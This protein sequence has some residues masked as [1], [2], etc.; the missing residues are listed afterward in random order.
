MGNKQLTQADVSGS[1][2]EQLASEALRVAKGY[3]EESGQDSM[4]ALERI[5]ARYD[6]KW[7]DVSQNERDVCKALQETPGLRADVTAYLGYS[8]VMRFADYLVHLFDQESISKE[9]ITNDYLR[10]ALIVG[11]AERLKIV[12]EALRVRK[13]SLLA[14]AW[15]LLTQATLEKRANSILKKLDS[16]A[17]AGTEDLSKA[18]QQ[19]VEAVAACLIAEP[20]AIAGVCEAN[21][22]P[23]PFRAVHLKEWEEIQKLRSARGAG[24]W[25]PENGTIG[26]ALSGGGIRSATFNLGVLQGLADLKLLPLFDYLSTVSGGG[27]IGSWL[28]AWLKR[29]ARQPAIEE[30]QES[31]SPARNPDPWSEQTRP[32]RWL[33]SFSNYLTPS[34]G[35]FSADVWTAAATY[36][37]NLILNLGVLVPGMAAVLLI[38]RMAGYWLVHEKELPANVNVYASVLLMALAI[39]AMSWNLRAVTTGSRQTS[40]FYSPGYIQWAIV[41]P[42]CASA[43]FISRAFWTGGEWLFS[44]GFTPDWKASFGVLFAGVAMLQIFG[45]FL[46][47]F[48]DRRGWRGRGRW[49]LPR[50]I[51]AGL[52]LIGVAACCALAGVLL[53]RC[54]GAALGF[55]ESLDLP[56]SRWHW[57]IWGPPLLVLVSSLIIILQMGLS[58]LNF[59]DA[60]REWLGRL[61]AC[62]NIW[63]VA[64]LALFSAAIYGPWLIPLAARPVGKWI[65][66]GAAASWALLTIGS[67]LGARSPATAVSKG[68]SA[69][70]SKLDLLV[71]YGPYVFMIGFVVL[72]SLGVHVVLS[73]GALAADHWSCLN[74]GWWQPANPDGWWIASV[75]RLLIVSIVLAAL[76]SWRID[77]NEF[78]MHHF[79]KNRLVRC[80]LGASNRGRNPNPF[81][82]FD[83]NDDTELANLTTGDYS[84]PFPIIN[85]TLNVT[86]GTD[87]AWQQ[88]KASSFVFTPLYSGFEMWPQTRRPNDR[89]LHDFGFRKTDQYAYGGG[90]KIGTAAAIS[91]AAANPN[92]G[93]HTSTA[94]AFL[95]TVFNVRLGWW[96]G[97]PRR[98]SKYPPGNSQYQKA[99][100]TW[101]LAYLI[102]NL[103]G[104]TDA[105]AGFVNLSDGGHFDNMGLYELIRRRC[106]YIVVCDAEEDAK[107]TFGGLAAAL[108]RCRADFG[109]E[110][111]IDPARIVPGKDG[112][113]KTHCVVGKISYRDAPNGLLVYLKSS[114]TENDPADVAEYAANHHGFPHQST[115][116]QWFDESQFESYRR[117]GYHVALSTFIKATKGGNIN[118]APVPAQQLF[119][120][121]EKL[122]YP[123]S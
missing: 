105:H 79:Y 66:S 91:G 21:G 30:V 4:P 20:A 73:S 103:L 47:C 9:K 97:N 34:L 102:K 90:I 19:C 54:V 46:Q 96:I 114:L 12:K 5:F 113:S 14:R 35:A 6:K 101:G 49:T 85:T 53:L 100:P 78:S 18:R 87:L 25:P 121:I 109:V 50:G 2:S 41:L 33:R 39:G 69:G 98:N 63:T 67:V 10:K 122:W 81:T 44:L 84:G 115:A 48:A 61:R 89:D 8:D 36:S 56:Q 108:R 42:L 119:E 15:D 26:L 62:L 82:G 86:S 75:C 116:D 76:L 65:A 112:R 123:T 7:K 120:E 27:Y 111:G 3:R 51:Y 52:A 29:S 43:F 117:L 106:R 45:G 71:R 58:S 60:G 99:S 37:R 57:M 93:F 68:G 74:A 1:Y 64:W 110:I 59:P 38:P 104:L 94:A 31:L 24:P 55:A 118:P 11:R 80:Y 17:A 22:M 13:R 95:M 28:V 92:Q 40:R 88:R 72:V 70:T 16:E 23:L 32:I 83:S 77:I 107:Y